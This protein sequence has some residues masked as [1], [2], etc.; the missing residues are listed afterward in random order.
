VLLLFAQLILVC[1]RVSAWCRYVASVGCADRAN[2]KH[3]KDKLV[4][5]AYA[6]LAFCYQVHT[7]HPYTL[8][9]T[10]VKLCGVLL[11]GTWSLCRRASLHPARRCLSYASS[12]CG[13]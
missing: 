6:I 8:M 4:K 13:F 10:S 1:A 12:A 7:D 5:N 11:V 3:S 9:Y 2:P